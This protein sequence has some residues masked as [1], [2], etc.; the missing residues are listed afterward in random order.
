M[1]RKRRP[2]I[3]SI[4]DL[5]PKSMSPDA[6]ALAASATRTYLFLNSQQWT[7]ASRLQKEKAEELLRET[8]KIC[9]SGLESAAIA[10]IVAAQKAA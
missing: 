8:W 5:I 6:A 9:M 1:H 10:P 3:P 2:D 4:A 7:A